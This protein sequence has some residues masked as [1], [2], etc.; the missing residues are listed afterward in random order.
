V[1]R[2]QA[3][4]AVREILQGAR[5]FE[6]ER[7]D[8]ISGALKNVTPIQAQMGLES[9]GRR[10]EPALGMRWRSQT[11]FLPLV[12][13]VYSQ[14]MKVDNYL[15][16]D[17]KETAN[18][19]EWWQRNKMD[20]RQT[21]VIRAALAYGV[22]YTTVL[23][24]LNPQGGSGAFLRPVSPRQMT[25]VYGEPVEWT[26]GETPVDDDWP[27]F[28]LE[29]K[30][31]AIRLYDE[32]KVHFLGAKQVP[33]SA[34]GWT[35]PLFN[36]RDNLEYIEARTHDVGVCPVVRFRDKWEMDG[37][38]TFGIVEP[39][40]TIQS[41]I[42]ETT[43]NMSAAE[44]F[45]AFVQRWVAGWRPQNDELAMVAGDVWYFNK[46]DVKVGQ[47]DAGDIKGYIESKQSAVRDLAAIGQIP[48]Q[49]LGVDAL[50]NISEATLAGLETGKKRKT[51][52]I[53]T[54]L[55]ESFEQML[56]TCAYI[57]GDDTSAMD[58]ASEV[59]WADLTARTLAETTDALVKWV[60]GLGV[61][62]ELA[63]ESLPGWTKATVE[64]AKQIREDQMDSPLMLPSQVPGMKQALTASLAA[65]P[66][67]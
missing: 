64:R 67:Q 53:Q 22:G 19:W 42:T 26:P 60:A 41:R 63:W 50:S 28:A 46:S 12:V 40:L 57:T 20:A 38:E 55:G 30:G 65:R 14:S 48:A 15:A 5:V 52:E 11:N 6:A 66:E 35:D 44:Y 61:P 32:E 34:L 45:T 4:D 25:C 58:F 23:P 10:E 51:N 49:N 43:Y 62:E 24:S 27:I 59:K 3:V 33:Q 56:R 2:S 16:S 1:N 29:V 36:T 17:T 9:S 47:F 13:D 54:A 39:L 21:G 18:P 7:L 8:V 31:K 37:E